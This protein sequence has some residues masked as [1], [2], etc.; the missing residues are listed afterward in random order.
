M[1]YLAVALIMAANVGTIALAE[2]DAQA[3]ERV[4][5]KCA[6]CHQIG[7][8]AKNRV[9]PQLT[10]VVGRQPGTAEGFNYSANMVAFGED[11][12][13]W[14]EAALTEFLTKPRDFIA[15]TKMTFAGLKKP[16]EIED[17]IAYL[18]SVE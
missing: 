11:G 4:F 5:R 1:K 12:N 6:A 7:A 9:G 8:D 16:Q 3:G 14:D 13:V 15:G 17:I 18:E 2:G 10:H